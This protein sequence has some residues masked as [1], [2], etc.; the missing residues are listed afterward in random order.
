MQS[1][2]NKNTALQLQRT[3]RAVI[4]VVIAISTTTT[5]TSSSAPLHRSNNRIVN[6][7]RVRGGSSSPSWGSS[8]PSCP[9]H[10]ARAI[11]LQRV[12][13]FFRMGALSLPP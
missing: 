9:L 1:L 8:S 5:I 3:A 12:C 6:L 11:A 4:T 13:P 7:R 2:R 10:H